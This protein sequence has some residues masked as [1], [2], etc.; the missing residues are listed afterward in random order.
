MTNTQRVSPHRG[1]LLVSVTGGVLIPLFLFAFTMMSADTLEHKLGLGWLVN[2]L[3]LSFLAPMA[4]W[5]WV[6]PRLPPCPSCG[7][8]DTAIVATIA[9]VFVFYAVATYL[10]LMVISRLWHVKSRGSSPTVKEGSV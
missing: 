4:I 6:F 8:T 3:M 2:I 7:P 10:I 9:T 5:E 1:T